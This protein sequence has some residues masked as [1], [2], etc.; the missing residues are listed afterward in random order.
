MLTVLG[1]LRPQEP[2]E[3]APGEAV[4]NHSTELRAHLD[5][6]ELYLPP[7]SSSL[8]DDTYATAA[9]A[10]D[11]ASRLAASN[12]PLVTFQSDANQDVP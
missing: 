9:R 10:G 5:A 8:L 6:I 7:L 1:H 4:S 2:G 11:V 12:K 3:V